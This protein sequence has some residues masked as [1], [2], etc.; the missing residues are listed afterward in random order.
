MNGR[1]RTGALADGTIKIA[2]EIKSGPGL[3]IHLLDAV[4]VADNFPEDDRAQ[5]SFFRQGPE[6]AADEDLLADFGGPLLP[7]RERGDFRKFARRVLIADAGKRFRGSG[8]RSQR[9]HKK[10]AH[11][12]QKCQA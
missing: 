4:T 6:A 7:L 3:E 8:G 2:R 9:P 5:R 11:Q 10:Q 12:K 1:K